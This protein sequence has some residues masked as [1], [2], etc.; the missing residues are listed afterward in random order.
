MSTQTGFVS[1][2][3]VASDSNGC[4]RMFHF[5]G[6]MCGGGGVR[7]KCACMRLPVSGENGAIAYGRKRAGCALSLV[8]DDRRGCSVGCSSNRACS[9]IVSCRVRLS[10]KRPGFCVLGYS[11]RKA[12]DKRTRSR[13]RSPIVSHLNRICLGHTRTCTG[14]NSCSRTRTSLG[15]VHRHSLPKENCGSLGTSGTGIQVRGRE[16]LRLTC[17]TR[18]DCSMFHGYRALAHGCPKM[19]STVLRVPTASCQIVCFVPRDTVG[20]CPK[21]LARGPADG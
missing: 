16:R 12:T 18:H 10:D 2:D 15:V 11:G 9:N 20:S 3:C 13:L 4:I 1:P 7:A 21:A 14:G 8:G 6:G 19:R 17:R 5:V